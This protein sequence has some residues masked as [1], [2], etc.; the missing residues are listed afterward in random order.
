MNLSWYAVARH[1]LAGVLTEELKLS[2]HGNA[3]PYASKSDIMLG[4][5]NLDRERAPVI[6]VALVGDANK[7]VFSWISTYAE[8]IFPLT[9]FCRVCSIDEWTLLKLQFRQESMVGAVSP[10]WSSIV[11]G[12][13]LGQADADTQVAGVPLARANACFSFALA[14]TLLLYPNN[15]IARLRCVEKL[16][17]AERDPRFGYRHISVELIWKVWTVA[18]SLHNVLSFNSF[19]VLE[20]VLQIVSAIDKQ[21]APILATNSLLLSDSAEDRV[22]GFDAIADTLVRKFNLKVIE[23]QACTI[24]LAAAAVLAGRGTSHIHLLSPIAK[25]FPEV[26]VWY[27]L[28]SGVLGPRGWDKAWRQ[29]T[30][31]V[32]R[33]LRQLFRPDEPVTADICWP[34]YEWLAKTYNSSESLSMIPKNTSRSLTIELLPG[35]NCQFRLGGQRSNVKTN[36]GTRV[37]E[38]YMRDEKPAITEKNLAQA[39]D[40]LEHAQHLL[41][42]HTRRPI[43]Q[44]LLEEDGYEKGSRPIQRKSK[45]KTDKK[46]LK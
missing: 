17:I 15:E 6:A 5:N 46:T 22:D 40:L 7:E 2:D 41:R 45:V 3:D 9:Q 26:L 31:G 35:V 38:M 14:R 8:E 25:L 28:F 36:E 27:G 42:S 1:E 43:Q 12:E 44:S 13:M 33:A 30:K 16:G 11:L 32:E 29:Q 23:R 37:A 21:A 4:I 39:I 18:L 24:T 34:E 19:N 20:T 10:I